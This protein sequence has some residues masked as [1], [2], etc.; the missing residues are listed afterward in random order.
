MKHAVLASAADIFVTHD[1]DLANLMK[2]IPI[3]NFEVCDLQD[4]LDKI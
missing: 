4:L 2:R 1:G 3:E